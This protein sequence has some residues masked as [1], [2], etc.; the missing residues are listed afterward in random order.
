MFGEANSEGI[1][2]TALALIVAQPPQYLVA[3][4][5]SSL[6]EALSGSPD[7]PALASVIIAPMPW[8]GPLQKAASRQL[9]MHPQP[10]VSRHAASGPMKPAAMLKPSRR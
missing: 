2:R 4:S 8:V 1:F 5:T 7:V 9:A 6:A 10:G 3:L